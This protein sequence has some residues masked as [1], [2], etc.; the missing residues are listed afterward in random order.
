[1]TFNLHSHYQSSQP[2]AARFFEAAL[3]GGHLAHAYLF[4]GQDMAAMYT[5]AL[6]LAKVLNCAQAPSPVEACGD[7]RSC[8]WI[9]TNAHP[10]LI[11]LSRLTARA[12]EK[13]PSKSEPT[14]IKGEQMAQLIRQLGMSSP[15]TRVVILTDVEE[16]PASQPS[17]ITPPYEWQTEAG[18]ADKSLHIRPLN[19]FVLNPTSA[20]RFLKTLEEPA[21]RTLFILLTDAVEN[22]LD[23]LVSRC[24]AVPFSRSA[25]LLDAPLSEPQAALFERL[26]RESLAGGSLPDCYAMTEAFQTQLVQ[27][28]DHTPLQGLG[29]FQQYLRRRFTTG[30]VTPER[31]GAYRRFQNNLERAR[32]MLTAKTHP[33]QT[34]NHLFL[35][36]GKPG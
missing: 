30:E 15:D 13:N 8:K 32:R 17:G 26:F 5:F 4:Y 22:V 34:L 31:Y 7:C 28:E 25:D 24:Q 1:M 27:A 20:N 10:A 2:L 16:T 9:A 19:R 12:P 35:N 36:L 14:Q 21:P 33:E 6:D 11:T 3:T 18:H 23:T 29:L